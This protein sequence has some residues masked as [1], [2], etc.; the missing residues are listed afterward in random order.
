MAGIDGR[1]YCYIE[2]HIVYCLI[3][4]VMNFV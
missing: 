4:S 1:P 2:S 3:C